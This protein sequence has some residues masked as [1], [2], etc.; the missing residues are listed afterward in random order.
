VGAVSGGLDADALMRRQP[1][2]P[3]LTIDTVEQAA[4]LARALVAGGLDVMEVTLRTPAALDAI[5]TIAR[6]VPD[7]VLGAG[8]V[9][10]CQDLRAAL[11]AGAR[12]IVTPGLTDVLLD[13]VSTAGVPL[14]PGVATASEVMRGLDA[15]LSRFKF[16]P[17]EAAGGAATLAAFAGPFAIARFCPT[18]GVSAANAPGYLSLTNVL[19]VG[20]GWVAPAAAVRAGD[21]ARITALASEAAALEQPNDAPS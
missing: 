19:C 11:A 7:A 15:G 5:E 18:G 4:P 2:I 10:N 8:T 16:F 1:V 21:W 14:L 20:G 13:A 3:I 17:A 12:F 9:L 6:E